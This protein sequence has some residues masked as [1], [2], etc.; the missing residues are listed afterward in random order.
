VNLE[1]K[2]GGEAVWIKRAIYDAFAVIRRRNTGFAFLS[3][4]QDEADGALDG[5]AK[6]AYCRM[7]EAAH[8]EGNMRHTF[9]ITHSNEVRAMIGQRID[10]EELGVAA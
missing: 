1:D 3:C 5:A 10:M 9:V 6:T 8:A 4:F 2:S 7:L